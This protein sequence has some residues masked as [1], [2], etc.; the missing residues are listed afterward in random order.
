VLAKI[1]KDQFDLLIFRPFKPDLSDH[2]TAYLAWGLFVTWIVGVGRYWDHP[3]AQIW[4]Y[5][6]LGSIAY[7]FILA[8]FIWA[9]AAPLQPKHW[10]YRNVLI[11][12][13]LTSLPALL[14]AIPVERFMSLANA[15][16]A[17]VW[18]LAVVAAWRVALLFRFFRTVAGLS[19]AATCVVGLLPLV[20]I[21][22]A[23]VVLNLENAV[24]EIMGGLREQTPNDAAYAVLILITGASVVAS[25]FLLIWYLVLVVRRGA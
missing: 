25:P 9:I 18:F 14:Y 7:V 16:T 4:Q 15:Q 12:V 6:G 24:F 21:V 23:L 10:S 17:N 20:L 13:T 22:T 8:L 11:F 2:W 3:S 5:L 1:L 19:V